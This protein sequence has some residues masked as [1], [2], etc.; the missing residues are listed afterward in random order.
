MPFCL[1]E[2]TNQETDASENPLSLLGSQQDQETVTG[3]RDGCSS[4]QEVMARGGR[5]RIQLILKVYCTFPVIFLATQIPK[6]LTFFVFVFKA[7]GRLRWEDCEFK[8]SLGNIARPS[9]KSTI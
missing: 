1:Q 8:A 2:A 3:C 4:G 7:L 9:S 6:G 5:K